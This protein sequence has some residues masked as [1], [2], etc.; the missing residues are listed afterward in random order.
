MADDTQR[1]RYGRVQTFT[2]RSFNPQAAVKYLNGRDNLIYKKSISIFGIDIAMKVARQ[3]GKVYLVEGAPD[4]MRLQSLEI[5]NVIASL[6]GE[7]VSEF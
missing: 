1:D 3:S 4:V 6:G 5:A 2:A 7:G